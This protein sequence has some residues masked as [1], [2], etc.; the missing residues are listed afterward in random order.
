MH[1]PVTDILQCHI[2]LPKKF[3]RIYCHGFWSFTVELVLM[4]MFKTSD[5]FFFSF[6]FY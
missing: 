5:F 3:R 2:R 1:Q 4:L 6:L